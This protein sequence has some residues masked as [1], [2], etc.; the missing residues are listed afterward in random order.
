MS[1]QEV[2]MHDEAL[3]DVVNVHIRVGD[4]LV[5]LRGTG[6]GGSTGT[7]RRIGATRTI[8]ERLSRGAVAL[9][10]LE[11][12]YIIQAR[13]LKT[14][15]KILQCIFPISTQHACLEMVTRF[16]LLIY[17]KLRLIMTRRQHAL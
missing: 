16:D 8:R 11:L 6:T 2:V 17:P 14:V 3:I 9:R 1:N 15:G 10:V 7:C 13:D 12:S 5:M 4:V